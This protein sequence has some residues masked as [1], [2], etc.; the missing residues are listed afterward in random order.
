MYRF[1]DHTADI[2][3]EV[4]AENLEELVCDAAIAFYSAFTYLEELDESESM[5][6]SLSESNPDGLLFS[7]LN[8]LLFIFDT[9]HFAGKHVEVKIKEN[10]RIELHGKIFGGRLSP[11]KVK[12]EPKAITLHNFR[13]EKTER[14]WR[15]FVVVDI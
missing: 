15:A 13:V 8:E 10:D 7:W 12:L 6:V 14:G 9:N 1:I 11:E 3:F 2:A 4:E 5:E